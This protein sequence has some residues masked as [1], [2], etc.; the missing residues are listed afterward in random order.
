MESLPELPDAS[1]MGMLLGVSLIAGLVA[2]TLR[3]P[4]VT[5]YLT[6]GLVLG[7]G[8]LDWIPAEHVHSF[9]PFLMLAM[10]LVLFTLGCH[11]PMA[12][13]RRIATRVLPLSFG[14]LVATF[15]FVA[16]G[17][18]LVGESGPKAILLGTLALATAPATTVLVLKELRSEGPVTEFSG[19][20]VALNNLACIVFFEIAFL[21]VGVL[22]GNAETPPSEQL[23]LLVQDIAGSVVLGVVFGLI[24]SY[25]C[26]LISSSKWLVLL[27]A[28]STFCLGVCEAFHLP[29]MLTFLVMGSVVASTWTDANEL[30]VEVDHV[31]G[32]L[33][34]LFFAVHGAEL[35]LDAFFKAGIVGVTYVVCRT[36]GKF[37]G[38]YWSASARG[39]SEQ[40]KKYLGPSL[41]AQAGAAIALS[42]IAAHRDPELGGELK[43]IILG[44]VVVFELVGPVLIRFSVLRA[45]EVPIS[46]AIRHTSITPLQQ[47]VN[48]W[49][50][51]RHL[52][53]GSLLSEKQRAELTVEE[54]IRTNIVEID[55]GASF[56]SVLEH[57]ETS[58]DNTYP[59]VNK[60]SSV[61]GLIRYRLLSNVL[62][63]PSVT[64]LVRAE[65]LA[66][67]ASVVLYPDEPASRAQEL[68]QSE[69]DDLIPVVERNEPHKL[70]GAVRRSD[71]TRLLISQQQPS[72]MRQKTGTS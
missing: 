12:R 63:D 62:F 59:V 28:A 61:V 38:V 11:F 5:A 29:Y 49:Y 48:L 41:M 72:K 47:L 39:E 17:L 16:V 65:D 44:S 60:E 71:V 45:G 70:L 25:G 34:V 24:I 7:P 6:V 67:P 15:G 36:L 50:R 4:K 26:G 56:S 9:E 18:L 35:D 66:T 43:A 32:L 55:E 46:Q 33:C 8:F 53:F 27:V 30:V 2:E 21:L 22:Q 69:R 40:I 52:I 20:L 68:F 51:V 19:V 23:M 42:S 31:T 64:N 14:E 13:I 54:L 57:I 58:H 10:A 37:L 3:L 1:T